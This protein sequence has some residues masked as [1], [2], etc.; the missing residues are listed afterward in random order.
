[1]ASK[2]ILYDAK[3]IV[4]IVRCVNQIG[5]FSLLLLTLTELPVAIKHLYD[6]LINNLMLL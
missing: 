3:L 1:M 6:N 5:D 4:L 2:T